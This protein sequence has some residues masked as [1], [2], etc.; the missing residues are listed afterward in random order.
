MNG[1]DDSDKSVF[2]DELKELRT[3]KQQELKAI[4]E[5][6]TKTLRERRA[7]KAKVRNAQQNDDSPALT[8]NDR[9]RMTTAQKNAASG[10][11]AK[12]TSEL[13]LD[14]ASMWILIEA[15]LTQTDIPNA[16]IR[17]ADDITTDLID[18]PQKTKKDKNI[19]KKFEDITVDT[20]G[21]FEV[22][23]SCSVRDRFLGCELGGSN[24]IEEKINKTATAMLKAASNQ[25][26]KRQIEI[27]RLVV[28]ANPVELDYDFNVDTLRKN[29]TSK[30]VRLLLSHFE[31]IPVKGVKNNAVKKQTNKKSGKKGR[32]T[33][34]KDKPIE[35]PF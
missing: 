22:S 24:E 34:P 33:R 27:I 9:K 20:N 16:E 6:H 8:A 19:I 21:G 4:N 26:E 11:P 18:Y 5:A 32:E 12:G 2:A 30:D 3:A 14:E 17:L 23:L 10:K 35:L 7:A 28:N 1:V 15:I 31:S 13:D 29:N 25:P